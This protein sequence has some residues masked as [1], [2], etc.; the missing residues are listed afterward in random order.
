MVAGGRVGELRVSLA[1]G[2]AVGIPEL[3]YSV[4]ALI[5]FADQVERRV[6]QG[7][8]IAEQPADCLQAASPS[9]S[10]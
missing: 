7:R 2:F 8:I 10:N 1:K 9:C 4:A 5:V 6:G 3:A